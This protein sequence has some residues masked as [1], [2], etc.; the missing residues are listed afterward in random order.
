MSGLAWLMVIP[1]IIVYL[2]IT[3]LSAI[4][5]SIVWITGSDGLSRNNDHYFE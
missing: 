2:L 3:T 5:E 4:C 1:T